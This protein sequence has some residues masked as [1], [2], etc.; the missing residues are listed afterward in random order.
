MTI[1]NLE[2]W[3]FEQIRMAGMEEQNNNHAERTSQNDEVERIVANNNNTQHDGRLRIFTV[4]LS[5]SESANVEVIARNS[6]DARDIAYELE[7]RGE[8]EFYADDGVEVYDVYEEGREITD[9][10]IRNIIGYENEIYREAL[11][12]EDVEEYFNIRSENSQEP[13]E[14]DDH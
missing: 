1:R 12:I 5:R 7:S 2:P 8:I 10:E 3:N 6:R 14:N 9:S 11:G 13:E 4:A